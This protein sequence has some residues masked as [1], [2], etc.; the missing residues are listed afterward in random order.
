VPNPSRGGAILQ[1][2]T[3][4]PSPSGIQASVDGHMP[5]VACIDCGPR[6]GGRIWGIRRRIFFLRC[7]NPIGLPPGLYIR[8]FVKIAK[9]TAAQLQAAATTRERLMTGSQR[10]TRGVTQRTGEMARICDLYRRS[11]ID[12]RSFM[13]ALLWLG[14]TAGAAGELLANADSARAAEPKKGGRLRAAM[15][16]HGPDDTLDPA[17]AKAGIDYCRGFQVYNTLVDLDDR[18]TPRPALAESWEPNENATEWIFHLRQ[19]V[20]FHNGK[21]FTAADVLY[22]IRRHLDDSVGSTGK[23]FVEEVTDIKAENSRTVRFTLT[24]PNADFPVNLGVFQMFI[25]PDGHTDFNGNPVGTGPFVMKEFKPGIRSL[26]ARNTNYWRDGRPYLDEIEWFAIT[27]NV[28]R[29]NALLS[30]DIQMMAE[31]D[32]KAVPEVEASSDVEAISTRSG[33]F[34]DLVMMRDREPFTNQDLCLA[35]KHLFD[36][37]RIVERVFKGYGMVGAD[38]PISPVDPMYCEAVAPLAYDLDRARFHLKKAGME[39]ARIP[40][41]TSEAAHSNAIDLALMIQREARKISLDLELQRE[42]ADGY[43]SN[44]WMQKPMHMAGWNMRPT[45]NIML[46]LALHSDAKWNESSFKNERFDRLLVESRGVTDSARRREMYCEMLQMVRD[47][48][49]LGIPAFIDYLDAASSK[50]K[51]IPAVPL[52]PLGGYSFPEHVWLDV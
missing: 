49:G 43:W 31:L 14:V 39:N 18:I 19:G 25:V 32:V 47:E 40:L 51:G 17:K 8:K 20:E 24:G 7:L 22:S 2:K 35:I 9:T 10:T 13:Q 46:T 38:H 37:K 16:Q 23:A 1:L 5:G 48:A 3:A 11:A 50:V 33:Q 52:G 27:D 6:P 28:A 4:L 12:R 21:S 44:V 42:P 30:G 26:A 36:R 29:L 15:G 41:H 34:V 45:A